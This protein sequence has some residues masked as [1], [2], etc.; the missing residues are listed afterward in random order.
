VALTGKPKAYAE[1]LQRAARAVVLNAGDRR[2]QQAFGG[3][4]LAV[5]VLW[6]F[7]TPRQE[8]WGQLHAFKPDC[9]NL[10]KLALDCMQRAGALGGDDCRVAAGVTRKEWA[11]FGRVSILIE[12]AAPDGTPAVRWGKKDTLSAPP[13]WLV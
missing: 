4:A 2:V 12:L 8:R 5:S 7:P 9:D 6:Q 3:H 13:S 10:L 1:A 11:R